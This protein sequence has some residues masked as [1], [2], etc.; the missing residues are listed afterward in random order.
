M[1]K[2]CFCNR[3]ILFKNRL[4]KVKKLANLL[5]LSPGTSTMVDAFK[6]EEVL[7]ANRTNFYRYHGS[8][9]TPTCDQTVTWSLMAEPI[10]ISSD[11]VRT[12]YRDECWFIHVSRMKVSGNVAKVFILCFHFHTCWTHCT[13]GIIINNQPIASSVWVQSCCININDVKQNIRALS[14]HPQHKLQLIGS[15]FL[16]T[17]LFYMHLKTHSLFL[18]VDRLL[19]PWTWLTGQPEQPC[20]WQACSC[21]LEQTPVHCWNH[22]DNSTAMFMH[23]G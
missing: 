2:L 18:P 17:I 13:F 20:C 19:K 11:Q 10:E 3:P 9:T 21:M 16:V 8:L 12:F 22:H 1:A 5:L 23:Q 7:P 14:G 6:V 4:S 15:C